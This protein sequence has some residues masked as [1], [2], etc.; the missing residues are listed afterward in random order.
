MNDLY[1]EQIRKD[2]EESYE[3]KSEQWMLTEHD[4][5]VL[6]HQ[7]IN[8]GSY[9]V[10]MKDDAGLEDEVKKFNTILL[11]LGFFVLSNSKRIRNI[12]IHAIDG[13]PKK[14]CIMKIRIV[15]ILKTNIGINVIKL[16]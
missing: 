2:I 6:D 9:I 4:E 16:D 8:Y 13:F 15:F 1:G 14:N 5:P 11:Q 10:K 3:G 12:F 7:K